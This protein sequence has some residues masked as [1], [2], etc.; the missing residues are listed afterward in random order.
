MAMAKEIRS[1]GSVDREKLMN[2]QE[3]LD[4]MGYGAVPPALERYRVTL[5]PD[6]PTP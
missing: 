4:F 1:R 3:F 5:G 2:F 6:S